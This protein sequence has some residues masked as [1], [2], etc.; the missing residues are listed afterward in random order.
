MDSPCHNLIFQFSLWTNCNIGLIV[1]ELSIP[2]TFEIFGLQI[3]PHI[4]ISILELIVPVHRTGQIEDF[5]H[6]LG[7]LLCAYITFTIP[8][9]YV[10][11]FCGCCLI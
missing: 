1:P 7:L 2:F 4:L 8:I 5:V 9:V 10:K 11:L 6:L 3:E